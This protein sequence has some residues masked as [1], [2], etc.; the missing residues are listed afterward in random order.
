[1]ILTKYKHTSL[2]IMTA[3]QTAHKPKYSTI[4]MTPQDKLVP[5]MCMM[6]P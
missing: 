5:G 6:R 3:K 1:M 4:N 2:L